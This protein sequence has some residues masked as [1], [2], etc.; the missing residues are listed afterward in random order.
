M[1]SFLTLQKS[2]TQKPV[3]VDDTVALI[4][5]CQGSYGLSERL[6]EMLHPGK[7]LLQE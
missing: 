2:E 4:D 3:E 7:M 6:N 5:V 1:A